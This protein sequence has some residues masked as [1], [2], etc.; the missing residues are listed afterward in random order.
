M[1]AQ[2]Y[3][4]IL[5][6]VIKAILECGYSRMGHETGFYRNDFWKRGYHV[7]VRKGSSTI[8]LHIHKDPV[9]H[10][11]KTR[12]KGSDLEREIKEIRRTYKNIVRMRYA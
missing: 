5:E 6:D 1:R 7:I 4:G 10:I 12:L 2:F 3:H 8:S 9:Y 11:G